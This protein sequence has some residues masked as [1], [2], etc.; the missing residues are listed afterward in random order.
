M[1]VAIVVAAILALVLGVVRAA[2]REWI[3]LDVPA[4]WQQA[5]EGQLASHEGYGWYRCYVQVPD[6]WASRWELTLSVERLGSAYEVYFNGERVAAA[7]ALPP[8]FEDAS[9]EAHRHTIPSDLVERGELNLIALRVYAP[10]PGDGGFHGRAPALTDYNREIVLEGPWQF[11]PGDESAWAEPLDEAPGAVPVYDEVVG[12]TQARPEPTV[13]QPGRSM[14]PEASAAEL[15]L[16]DDIA[17]DLVLADP[18]IEQPLH[19]SFDERGRLWLVEYRQYPY[20]AGLEMVSRDIYWRAVWEPDLPPPPYAEDSPFLGRD[21]ITVHEDT[22]GDGVYDSHEVFLDGLNIT[23]A[24]AHG[25]GG[26]WVLT[27]PHLVFYPVD[28][29]GTR[30]TG[31]PE[32]LLEGFGLEDTHSVVNSLT[33]GP[34]GW[35]YAAQGSTV[36]GAVRRPGEDE[37]P[38]RSIGQNIWRYHPE[39]REYEIFAEGGGNAFGVEIDSKG[40]TYSGHNGGDTRGFHYVQGGYYRKGWGK[41]GPLSNPHTFGYF[42]AMKHERVPRFTHTFLIYEAEALPERYRGNLLGVEPMQ[43]RIVNSRVEPHGSTLQTEDVDRPV[44]SNDPAFRPVDI[45]LAPDGSVYVA[46]F[47]SDYIAHGENYEGYLNRE[48]GRVYRLRGTDHEPGR[49]DLSALSTE[50]LIDRLADQNRWVRKAALRLLGDRRDAAAVPPLRKLLA[51]QTGQLAL[52]ALWALNLSGGFDDEQAAVALNHDD[53]HVRRWAVRLLGDDGRVSDEQ[54][55]RMAQIAADEPNVEVR[56]QLAS[57]AKRLPAE[58][59]LA[60]VAGLIT[61]DQ[62]VDDPHLPLLIWWAMEAHC[63]SDSREAVLAMF[64]AD[65]GLWD[66]P[67]VTEHLLSRVMRRFAVTGRRSDLLAGARLMRA[68][69]QR[70]HALLLMQGLE[71]AFESRTLSGLPGDLLD[72]MSEAGV[73][74]LV[75]GVRQGDAEAVEEALAILRDAE[76]DADERI[77][78]ARLFG[79][80]DEPRSVPAL[81]N[82]AEQSGS[83]ALRRAALSSLQS[84]RDDEIGQRVVA[85]YE[86]L[87]AEARSAAQTLL[88]GRS[89]WTLA[90]LQAIDTDQIDPGDVPREIVEAMRLHEDEQ[91]EVLLHRHFIDHRPPPAEHVQEEMERLTEVVR[92]GEGNPSA[93]KPIFMAACG[94]CHQMF[95]E[96]GYIG[97]DLTSY[98]RDDLH[99]LLRSIVDPNAD[100]RE[101][102]EGLI[103]TTEDGRT[104]TGFVA[105]EDSEVIVLRGLDGQNVTIAQDR[106]AEQRSMGRSLMPENLIAGLTDQQVRDLFAFLRSSQPVD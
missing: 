106:V 25:R 95:D 51:E 18:T 81:L 60:I 59:A 62:D 102:Y 79:E 32:V 16:A 103:V 57:T 45:K 58:Q 27:P 74:S 101:G 20:P 85:M 35:L 87:P 66:R 100:I 94:A 12:A 2:D 61:H 26:V 91:V 83:V 3:L 43:G 105:D 48:A 47:Y 86:D 67:M 55:A 4:S 31:E 97:P 49:V 69:P 80:V 71:D 23:T 70:E 65:E 38:V 44:I 73:A 93:G 42:P 14:E 19:V 36:S 96:G 78:Y 40:R 21:R 7:G 9:E 5:A 68:A 56:S 22:T 75:L 28:E 54:A 99:A 72:A 37:Q 92:S 53:P 98:Q 64:E 41:H 84:Y 33:W 34:D 39:T 89:A 17:A 76:A 63:G 104:V 77:D 50:Q 82:A 13:Y 11:R 88:A 6:N 30:I 52:E 90:W 10:E 8:D 15:E 24:V 1:A 29:S 46:D